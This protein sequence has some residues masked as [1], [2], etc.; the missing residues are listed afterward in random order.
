MYIYIFIL[1]ETNR[2]IVFR[3]KEREKWESKVNKK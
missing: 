2:M 1:I 3:E